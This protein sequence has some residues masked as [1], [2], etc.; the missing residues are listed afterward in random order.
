MSSDIY[1]ALFSI[2]QKICDLILLSSSQ[3]QHYTL[4]L[5]QLFCKNYQLTSVPKYA[6]Y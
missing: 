1:L 5:A 6:K 4:N 3:Q 2:A